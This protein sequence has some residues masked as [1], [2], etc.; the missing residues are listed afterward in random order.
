MLDFIVFG[1]IIFWSLIILWA[2]AVIYCVETKGRGELG[3]SSFWTVALL[4]VLYFS[5]KQH[6][7]PMLSN[8]DYLFLFI[9]GYLVVGIGWSFFRWLKF[10]KAEFRRWKKDAETN[11]YKKENKAHYIPTAG[12]NIDQL[13]A[14]L[15]FWPFSVIRY[16]VGDLLRDL[17]EM[18]VRTLGKAYDRIAINAF[19]E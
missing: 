13:T 18:F 8:A 9:V 16:I 14:W 11:N 2:I 4:A 15:I 3:W 19:K 12:D 10:V 7:L 17:G 5:N 6:L 1:G